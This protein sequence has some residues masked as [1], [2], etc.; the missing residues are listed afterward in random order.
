[1]ATQMDDASLFTRTAAELQCYGEPWNRAR[2]KDSREDMRKHADKRRG[3]GQ[4][5]LLMLLRAAW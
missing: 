2:Q 3:R 1:M 5:R 4:E